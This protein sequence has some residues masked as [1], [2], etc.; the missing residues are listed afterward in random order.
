MHLDAD[1]DKSITEKELLMWARMVEIATPVKALFFWA[2]PLF[3]CL[4]T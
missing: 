3:L 1:G 2:R 4:C